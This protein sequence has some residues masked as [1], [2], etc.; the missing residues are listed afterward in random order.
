MSRR[1]EPV[2]RV[3][4]ADVAQLGLRLSRGRV[5][6]LSTEHVAAEAGVDVRLLAAQAVVHVQRR[7][8]VVELL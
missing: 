1:A 5:D 7:D 6:H 8:G 3:R 2:G 4:V